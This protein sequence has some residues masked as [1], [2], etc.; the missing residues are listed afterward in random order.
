MLCQTT[1][2]PYQS[3]FMYPD[4]DATKPEGYTDGVPAVTVIISQQM[5]DGFYESCAD[6][7]PFFTIVPIAVLCGRHKDDCNASSL[8]SY[9]WNVDNGTAPFPIKYE[10]TDSLVISNRKQFQ[11]LNVYFAR[12]NHLI[13]GSSEY[14]GK[15]ITF[16]KWNWNN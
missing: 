4:I 1:C 6:L 9:M 10:V 13:E 11:P 14:I 16:V 2:S 3:K 7:R 12:C 5:A 15:L 8:L